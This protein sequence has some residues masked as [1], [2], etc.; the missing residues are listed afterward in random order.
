MLTDMD[1]AT[2]IRETRQRA[3]LSQDAL[4]ARAGTSQ[5]AVSRY[6]SGAASPSVETLDRLLAA[7]GARLELSA[8]DAPRHLDVRTPRMAK[9]RAHRD[10]IVKVAQRHGASNVRVF[11]S[12]ARGQDG[13][14][15][16]V[17]LLVDLDVRTRGL[18]PLGAL[19]DELSV[20]L[21][22]RVD[23]APADALAPHVAES[24]LAEAVPL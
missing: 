12:V 16:D 13:A 9:L 23:V 2:L 7:M 20:L 3:G 14:G 4:A 21:G 24:A 18:L 15:S 8:A 5:P 11:G 1:A 17:D 19:A 6:E 22:E 10:K